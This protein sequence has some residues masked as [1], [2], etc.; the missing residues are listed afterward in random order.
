MLKIIT[1]L[2]G[3]SSF[4][5]LLASGWIDL[6]LRA[7]YV[8]AALLICVAIFARRHW[9]AREAIAG[10]EPSGTERR[11]WLYMAGTAIICAYVIVVLLTPGSEVHRNSGDTG[12]VDSWTM[13]IGGA[14]A[15]AILIDRNAPRD[16]RDHII[17]AQGQKVGYASLVIF[18]IVF[19]LLLGFAPGPSMQRFTHWLIAN[20][21]LNLIMLSGLVQYLTQLILYWKDRRGNEVAHD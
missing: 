1:V 3:F 10:D 2:S 19:L 13:F 21:L 18:L 12:G 9:Q 11:V 7:G 6:P 4:G 17:D 14:I 16:E 5:A 15:W 20:T 8:G